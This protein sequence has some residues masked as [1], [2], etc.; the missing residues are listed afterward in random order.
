MPSILSE[1]NRSRLLAVERPT[2]RVQ[3]RLIVVVASSQS[4][5]YQSRWELPCHYVG[6]VPLT[7]FPEFAD[8]EV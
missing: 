1:H 4:V 5:G 3:S 8:M 6:L 2:R 7:L